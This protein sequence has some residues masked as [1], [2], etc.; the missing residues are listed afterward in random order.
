MI[1]YGINEKTLSRPPAPPETGMTFL[2]CFHP[3]S[4]TWPVMPGGLPSLWSPRP[5]PAGLLAGQYDAQFERAIASAPP[6]SLLT[7]WHEADKGPAAPQGGLTSAVAQEVHTYMHALVVRLG[8]KVRY[9]SVSTGGQR[10]SE[11]TVPG[12]DYYGVDMYDVSL[13]NRPMFHLNAWSQTQPP[14]PRVIAECNSSN[15]AHRPWWFARSFQWLEANDGIAMATFWL[16][17]GPL[18][19]PWLPGDAHTI[20]TLTQIAAEAAAA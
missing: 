8:H 9:G 3:M 20:A 13:D 11:W 1:L 10:T 18:S 5:D 19:G 2:R 16:P 14:G 12:L 17:S 7:T 6:G 15:P 4:G